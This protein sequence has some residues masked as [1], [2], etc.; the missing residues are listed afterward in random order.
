MNYAF[1]TLKYH[2]ILFSG[3]REVALTNCDSC[4]FN[5]GQ[6][7][8]FNGLTFLE[9]QIMEMKFCANMHNCKLCIHELKSL[10]KFFSAFIKMCAAKQF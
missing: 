6:K 10:M 9:K 5:K 1:K 8:I 4:I 3:L 2:E 7:K